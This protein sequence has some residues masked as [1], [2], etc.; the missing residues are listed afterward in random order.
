MSLV[1]CLHQGVWILI[2]VCGAQSKRRAQWQFRNSLTH[3]Y[4]Q[5]Q[6]QCYQVHKN[7]QLTDYSSWYTFSK[8]TEHLSLPRE[9]IHFSNWNNNI[10][11][12]DLVKGK[13]RIKVFLWCGYWRIAT[14]E[15]GNFVFSI[16]W[17]HDCCNW[18]HIIIIINY[19]R[20]Q[21][22]RI[23]SYILR[24]QWTTKISKAVW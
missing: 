11:S 8:D 16:Q 9:S 4:K 3:L 15:W 20:L 2:L 1:C 14:K 21:S 23:H 17:N 19:S 6:L 13:V 7:S 5:K 22:R 12:E 10:V 24:L 18:L